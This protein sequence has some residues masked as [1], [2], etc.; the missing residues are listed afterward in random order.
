MAN[1]KFIFVTIEDGES[2]DI[3]KF[4]QMLSV[5]D[6]K[7]NYEILIT[8]KRIETM[9]FEEMIQVIDICRDKFCTMQWKELFKE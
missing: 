9:T 6:I 4:R 7:D 2:E 8:T 3:E 1:K 5:Q